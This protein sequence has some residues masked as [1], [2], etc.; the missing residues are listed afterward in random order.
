MME[1]A[2]KV[3]GWSWDVSTVSQAYR[4]SPAEIRRTWS[5]WE[6]H[7]A[8]MHIVLDRIMESV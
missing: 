2:E 4:I 5:L 8:A 7:E 6:V 1:A 3:K